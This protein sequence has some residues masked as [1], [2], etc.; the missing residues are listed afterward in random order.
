MHFST[1]E[2]RMNQEPGSLSLTVQHRRSLPF[3]IDDT[4]RT[5]FTLRSHISCSHSKIEGTSLLFSSNIQVDEE[6]CSNRQALA[7]DFLLLPNQGK[8]VG[9]SL[10]LFSLSLSLLQQLLSSLSLFAFFLWSCCHQ[11]LSCNQIHIAINHVAYRQIA[12]THSPSVLHQIFC[13]KYNYL[14]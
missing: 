10:F 5:R 13:A 8:A 4:R 2:N 14:I 6:V 11:W 12:A 7:R 9:F 1:E 3:F